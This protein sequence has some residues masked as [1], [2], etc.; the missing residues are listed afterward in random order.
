MG[1][2]CSAVLTFIGY[3]RTDRQTSKQSIYIDFDFFRVNI[4]SL[5]L[6]PSPLES[7]R[8]NGDSSSFIMI[9]SR[10]PCL[11]CS[12]YKLLKDGQRMFHL[13]LYFYSE[14]GE[15]TEVNT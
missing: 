7:T 13:F 5:V 4:L 9:M 1:P 2:I 3:K 14:G 12:L 6:T 10:L 11:L 8:E 15:G